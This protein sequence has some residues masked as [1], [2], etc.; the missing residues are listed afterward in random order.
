MAQHELVF[1]HLTE[2]SSE[3]GFNINKPLILNNLRL[4]DGINADSEIENRSIELSVASDGKIS[5]SSYKLYN[6]LEFNQS[7]FLINLLKGAGGAGV[8][9]VG[10]VSDTRLSTVFGV[11]IL[12]G[13]FL[14]VSRKEYN[15]QDAKVLLAI[16]RLGKMCHISTIVREFGISFGE[17]IDERN[18]VDSLRVL[19]KFQ[20]I[21]RRGEEIRIIENVNISR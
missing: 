17:D 15:E 13:T 6:L 18:I 7:E 4:E 12:I 16:Y 8:P 10:I 20:T 9:L 19:E 21:E 2:L 14:G 1:R 5:A 11:L 3:A